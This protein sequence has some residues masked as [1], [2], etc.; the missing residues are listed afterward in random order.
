MSL[1]LK[2]YLPEHLLRK[3]YL[4]FLQPRAAVKPAKAVTKIFLLLFSFVI[5]F[6]FLISFLRDISQ[7]E[8]VHLLDGQNPFQIPSK[9]N[10]E[11]DFCLSSTQYLKNL[12]HF[13]SSMLFN[14]TRFKKVAFISKN[15]KNSSKK[16]SLCLN[17]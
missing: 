7:Q 5:M 6:S 4:S 9:L 3:L 17:H 11:K 13:S 1:L 15:F 10:L 8:S 14:V 2:M 16:Q 12:D